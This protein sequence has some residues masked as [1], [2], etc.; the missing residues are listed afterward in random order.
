MK[1]T[2]GVLALSLVLASCR[3]SRP[4]A[5]DESKSQ[6]Q[7]SNVVEMGLEAQKH[8]GLKVAPAVVAQ[9]SEYLN[10]TG[11]VQPIDSRIAHLR[12]L[13]RGRVLE[14]LAKVGD[15]VRSGQ[16]LARLDNIEAGELLAQ[17]QVAGA[18]LQKLRVQQAALLRQV[19]RNRRL[20]EIGAVPRKDAELVEAEQQ[21]L[22]AAIKGQVSL[23]EGIA[24][25]LRR[26][27]L[28]ED[29]Q[30]QASVTLILSPFGGVVIKA[31]AAP[32]EVVDS[33][34]E[35]FSIA[36]ISEVWVQA[37]VYEKDLGRIHL[38]RTAF[39]S[40][41]T[42]P[43]E[44]LPALVTYISD[45][46]DPQT[47]TAKVRCEVSNKGFRLKLDM[48][49]AVDVPTTFSRKAIAV[50]SGAIQQVEGKNVVFVRRSEEKFEARPVKLGKVV[51]GQTE[52]LAGL[53]EGQPTVVQGAFHLKSVA[54]G[55]KLAE[56]E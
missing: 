43:G 13:A 7:D 37:E 48:F 49:A 38:G 16:P 17:I 41:D 44:R 53:T 30:S 42:Y 32:G 28:S 56:E 54:M 21:G 39:V 20:L 29:T 11:T 52:I 35:L 25:R 15:R 24:A 8:V 27:G 31:Q 51:D 18:E 34:A 55:G 19:E 45:I 50:P 2:L 5:K 26:F 9:L 46:L 14:V 47:R 10:V 6:P 3:A 36:D 40:V 12:P 22:L 23:N 1:K 33:G 4:E